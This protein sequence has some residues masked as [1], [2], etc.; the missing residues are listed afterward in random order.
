MQALVIVIFVREVSHITP[1]TNSILLISGMM[2][3][4]LTLTFIA[5]MVIDQ[6]P[7]CVPCDPRSLALY[8]GWNLLA[9]FI[10]L[11]NNWEGIK[12]EISQ[13]I[14]HVSL[15]ENV[16]CLF[17]MLN[18]PV[19]QQCT[20]VLSVLYF[21]RQTALSLVVWQQLSG[22]SSAAMVKVTCWKPENVVDFVLRIWFFFW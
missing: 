15:T 22:V 9:L 14:I 6:H 11:N 13:A 16:L 4:I 1:L 17:H 19:M 18:L 10:Q 8:S 21:L 7:T 5:G 20:S 12:K 2:N 3:L